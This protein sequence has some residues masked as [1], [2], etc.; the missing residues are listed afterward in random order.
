MKNLLRTL[1]E[2]RAKSLCPD[3]DLKLLL[4]TVRDVRVNDS[5]ASLSDPFY[6][7]LENLLHDLRTISLDN[8]DAEAF[9]KPVSKADAPDYYDVIQTPMDLQTMLKK[10]K[11]KTYKSKK[12]FKDDLDLIWSNCVTYNAVETHPLR[13]CVKR[14][15]VKA[16]KLLT[17]ITDRKD[18]TDPGLGEAQNSR[19]SIK[20]NG[21]LNGH[22]TPGIAT[23]LVRRP[24][25]GRPSTKIPIILPPR[26]L[27]IS[28][29]ITFADSPALV[30]TPAGMGQFMELSQG[31]DQHF[32]APS[33]STDQQLLGRLR[34]VVPGSVESEEDEEMDI[35][36][37]A[38][39]STALAAL[40]SKRKLNGSPAESRPRKRVRYTN[41][42]SVPIPPDDD[43]VNRLWWTAVQ[44]TS[45]AANG[46]P[47]IPFA[48]SSSTPMGREPEVVKRKR[49][50]KRSPEPAKPNSLLAL[51]NTNIRTM[52]RVR[53]T[54]SKFAALGL[55]GS[56]NEDGEEPVPMMSAA[57]LRLE[58]F[59]DEAA[60]VDDKIDEK[61][62]SMKAIGKRKMLPDIGE[63]NAADC[64]GWMGGKVLEHAGFQGTSKVALDVLASVTSEYLMNVGRTIRYLSD[65][66][67]TAM[68]AEEII[69]H[70]LFESGIS[71]VQDLE[72][73]IKD[74][75]ERYGSRLGD[76]EKKLVGAYRETVT[77]LV[78]NSSQTAVDDGDDEGLFDEEDEEETGAL[79]RGD[80]ADTL[81]VDFFGFKE[82]GLAEEFGLSS[83]SIPQ[84]L[85]KGKR[86]RMKPSEIIKP[87]EPPPP[88]PPPPP[89]V[90]MTASQVD[91]QIGLLRP[92]Y[93]SRFT[94]LSQP[95][96]P[97]APSQANPYPSH[98][99]VIPHRQDHQDRDTV[100]PDDAAAP[101]QMKLG[102]IGHV[103]KPS[104]NASSSKKKAKVATPAAAG[105]PS[106]PKK[107]KATGVGTG[108][109]RKKKLMEAQLASQMPPYPPVVAA[110]A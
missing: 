35:K 65:K 28:Q 108:N 16:D 106:P 90:I 46:L 81:G 62:W 64:L 51:M 100:L 69:L 91:D 75:V 34:E 59:D 48:C 104:A 92:Y 42:C 19:V 38:D 52:K 53:H 89:F 9:L 57:G 5:K 61:S 93:L 66:H 56:N 3:N 78:D 73:Y 97:P 20:L 39:E 54:H 7:S 44:S 49:K 31:I 88:Y 109:G 85:L 63:E 33:T 24:P 13:Q 102:P 8:H 17:H 37:E 72:R 2:S 36:E 74:D 55:G 25:N 23:P 76:L 68:T 77:R 1:T 98:A 32:D 70:T 99:N 14:L 94:A 80:F 105:E 15:K 103:I 50:R 10:V 82:M 83:L 4:T 96:P 45:M 71:K 67:G 22:S 18:R 41:Q 6:D 21:H 110:S 11:Q 29:N 27:P 58:K 86:K 84:S 87:T 47:D 60:I 30:R 26:K 43:P 40:G 79:A 101:A 107:K 12:E 95:A